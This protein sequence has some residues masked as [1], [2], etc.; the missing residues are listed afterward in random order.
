MQSRNNLRYLDQSERDLVTRKQLTEH[1]KIVRSAVIANLVNAAI[2]LT[3]FFEDVSAMGLIV[4][5]AVFALA[6]AD[7][8]RLGNM[9]CDPGL[10]SGE[11]LRTKRRITLNAVIFAHV[12]GVGVAYLLPISSPAQLMLLAVIG[13]GKMSAGVMSY[14][15]LPEASKAWTIVLAT[16]L[17]TGLLFLGGTESYLA[18]C[19]RA[20][21][22]MILRRGGR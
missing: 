10:S 22:A 20:T 15:H 9:S 12:W 7:R 18:I 6:T 8:L 14:R 21:F 1:S 4:W 19:L 16:C 13:A 3:L 17:S 11:M 2:I 5:C